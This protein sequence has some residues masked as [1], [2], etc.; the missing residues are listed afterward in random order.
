MRLACS[1]AMYYCCAFRCFTAASTSSSFCSV[2]QGRF[3]IQRTFLCRFLSIGEEKMTPLSKKRGHHDLRILRFERT[4]STAAV[5]THGN[6]G[7]IPSPYSVDVERKLRSKSAAKVYE[8]SMRES[9]ARRPFLKLESFATRCEILGCSR[10]NII[11]LT[12]RGKLHPIK[13]SEKSILYLKSGIL[14]RNWQ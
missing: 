2:E 4:A 13:S 7:S 8:Q 10:Q 11:D 6:F 12:K 14:K 1:F 9:L 5:R 3:W